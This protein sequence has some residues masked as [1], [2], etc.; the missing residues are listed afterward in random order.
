MFQ[1]HPKF[2]NYFKLGVYK[3]YSLKIVSDKVMTTLNH[4]ISMLKEDKLHTSILDLL[5]KIH[6]KIEISPADFHVC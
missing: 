2:K 5:V 6:E 3:M 4:M 1:K